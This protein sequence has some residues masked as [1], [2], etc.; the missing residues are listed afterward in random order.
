MKLSHVIA[1][2]M[3]A[4]TGVLMVSPASAALK[5]CGSNKTCIWDDNDFKGTRADRSAG[6]ST[7]KNVP[8]TINNKMDSWANTSSAYVSCGWDGLNGTADHQ[9]WGAVSNDN[10]V[11]PFSSDEVSSWRTRYGC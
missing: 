5:D 11:S 8:T 9:T 1:G 6:E 2:V 7:I 3:I 10:N 4:G